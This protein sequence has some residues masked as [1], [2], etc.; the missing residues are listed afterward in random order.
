MDQC[1]LELWAIWNSG[2]FKEGLSHLQSTLGGAATASNMQLVK[3]IA[4]GFMVV[5]VSRKKAQN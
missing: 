1:W 3:G 4:L 2:K 5:V